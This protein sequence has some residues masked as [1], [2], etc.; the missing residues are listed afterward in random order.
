M[1]WFESLTP[2][3]GLFSILLMYSS[4][5][6][7]FSSSIMAWKHRFV[8]LSAVNQPKIPTS[9]KHKE[10]LKLA[11]LGEKLITI[12]ILDLG[13]EGLSEILLSSFPKLQEGGGFELCQCIPNTRTLSVLPTELLSSAILLKRRVKNSRTY[14]RPIQRNLDLAPVAIPEVRNTFFMCV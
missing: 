2:D 14:I 7:N 5:D 8:C 13:P 1:F 4:V 3:I 6:P 11:G 12:S 10:E 9:T